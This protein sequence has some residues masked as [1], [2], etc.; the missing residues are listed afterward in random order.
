MPVSIAPPLLPIIE[1]ASFPHRLYIH[2]P[3]MTPMRDVPDISGDKMSIYAGQ[4][5]TCPTSNGLFWGP[6]KAFKAFLDPIRA[7]IFHPFGDA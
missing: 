5:D 7:F 3:A 1:I 4:C 2:L 6:N